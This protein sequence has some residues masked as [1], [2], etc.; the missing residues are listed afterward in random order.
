MAMS[1]RLAVLGTGY[2]GTAQ[3][4]CL[5][6]LGFEVLGVD[7]DPGKIAALSNGVVPVHEPGLEPL[8]RKGLAEGRLSFTTSYAEAAAFGDVHFV[9]VGLPDEQ[10]LLSA[11]ALSDRAAH[12]G[13]FRVSVSTASTAQHVHAAPSWR[14]RLGL[15]R[16]RELYAPEMRQQAE[17]RIKELQESTAG[18]DA[19]RSNAL[20]LHQDGTYE[21]LPLGPGK[22]NDSS[23][24]EGRR[25]RD[26][27][28]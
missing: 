16:L 5:A 27:E 14:W 12:A 26:M 18:P 7:T 10:N 11:T 25:D 24:D 8:L 28:E 4:A 21:V 9:C 13:T 23:A 19:A 22:R 15:L 1:Y 2:L 17:E 20:L 6:S 3:A